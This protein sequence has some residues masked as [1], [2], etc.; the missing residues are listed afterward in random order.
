MTKCRPFAVTKPRELLG[1]TYIACIL[2]TF[3]NY[4]FSIGP[5]FYSDYDMCM[6]L[7]NSDRIILH[8]T[9]FAHC[10]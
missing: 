2:L 3:F 5:T 4:K 1:Y 6:T 8:R 9:S 10:W 7:Q